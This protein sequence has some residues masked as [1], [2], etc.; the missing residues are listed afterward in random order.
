MNLV[1]LGA[2]GRTGQLVIQEALAMGDT[3]TAVVRSETKRPKI[4]SNHL[5][6]V[7]GDP[8]DATFLAS[9]FKG[10]DA[11]ISTLGGRRPTK[12]AASVYWRSAEAI[13]TAASSVDLKRV[14]VTSSALLFHNRGL[15]DTLLATLVHSVVQSA[16]RMEK[17]LLD[18]NLDIIV[19]RCGFLTDKDER[20]YRAELDG[21]PN[22]GSSVSRLS[23][24]EFLIDKIREPTSGQ[25]IYGVSCPA[26]LL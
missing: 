16:T 22:C 26:K 6:T 19:G 2:N 18:T 24:A 13:I 3:V 11:V 15:I 1:V 14:A 12:K 5:K 17:I 7:V 20:G 23:L 8:C 25:H 4:E 10:Q 21:L 9:V